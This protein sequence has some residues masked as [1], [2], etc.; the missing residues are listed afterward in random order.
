MISQFYVDAVKQS[1]NLH[2]ARIVD[3]RWGQECGGVSI[4]ETALDMG[5]MS[6]KTKAAF[7]IIKQSKGTLNIY[8]APTKQMGICAAVEHGLDKGADSSFILSKRQDLNTIFRGQTIKY[9]AINL[10]FDECDMTIDERFEL[11]KTLTLCMRSSH[12]HPF[13]YIHIIRLGM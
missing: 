6:G 8:V 3:G 7:D 5:R 2:L 12:L 9:Q 4:F 10:I 11:A 13:P 1:R